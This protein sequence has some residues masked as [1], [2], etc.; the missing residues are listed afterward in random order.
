[1]TETKTEL[2][3]SHWNSSKCKLYF[4]VFVD[5]FATAA[6]FLGMTVHPCRYGGWW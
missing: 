6:T 1:M 4:I 2:K 5:I 3:L